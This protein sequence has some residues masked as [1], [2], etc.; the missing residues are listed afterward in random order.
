MRRLAA[1]LILTAAGGLAGCNLAE[2]AGRINPDSL[3]MADRCGEVMKIAM[4][5][6][7]IEIE[8]RFSE[9]TGVNTIVARVEAIRRDLPEDSKVAPDLAAECQFDS[10]ILVGFHWTQG[11]PHH[12]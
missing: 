12:P 11:G 2:R 8:K 4:P 1:I 9:N 3:G 5:F 10:N 6:A 7:D